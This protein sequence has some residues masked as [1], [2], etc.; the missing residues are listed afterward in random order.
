MIRIIIINK[1][2][3]I[4]TK[5]NQIKFLINSFYVANAFKFDESD[6]SILINLNIKK[7]F[8][9]EQKIVYLC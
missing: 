2:N 4:S 8:L 1:N 5:K 7:L 3:T 9:S 6:F